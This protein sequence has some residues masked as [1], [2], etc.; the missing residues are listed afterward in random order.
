MIVKR[1]PW[2]DEYITNNELWNKHVIEDILKIEELEEE[3]IMVESE[4]HPKQC[5]LIELTA[6][7]KRKAYIKSLLE[8]NR[9]E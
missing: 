3:V 7:D 9:N 1:L 8:A 4:E 5:D 2:K 6:E